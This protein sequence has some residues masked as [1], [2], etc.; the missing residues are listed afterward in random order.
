MHIKNSNNTYPCAGYRAGT[1][2][3]FWGV[4]GLTLP[5]TG[6][7]ELIG[8]DGFVLAEHDTGQYL[9]QTYADNTLTLTNEP[10][11]VPHVP[12]LEELR[13]ASLGRIDGKCSGAIYSGIDYD[14]K[15]YSLTPTAQQNI[16]NAVAKVQ[17]GATSVPFAA[18]SE[19]LSS[20]PAATITAISAKA[21]D[22]GTVN[23]CYKGK[24]T[25]WIAAETDAA[26]LPTINYGSGLPTAYM[27]ALGAQ[28][29]GFGINLA[30]WAGALGN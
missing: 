30:D 4:T 5:I 10:E 6:S 12:T 24:L 19:E 27:Q 21:N 28:L 17:A 3:K 20:Y 2:P 8:D 26:V 9:R 18:D 15:H 25:E 14:G 23:I 22:W 29:A 7:V 16:T 1:S 11:P 13:T